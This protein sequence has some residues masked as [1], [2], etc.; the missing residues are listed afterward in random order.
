MSFNATFDWVARGGLT[1]TPTTQ[2]PNLH[3]HSGGPNDPDTTTPSGPP[4]YRIQTITPNPSYLTPA[5]WIESMMN[6]LS[7]PSKSLILLESRNGPQEPGFAA[8]ED[9]LRSAI[10]ALELKEEQTERVIGKNGSLTDYFFSE[11][12]SA[13][14]DSSFEL[15]FRWTSMPGCYVVFMGRFTPKFVTPGGKGK[16]ANRM[17]GIVSHRGLFPISAGEGED[18]NENDKKEK[19]EK[20]KNVIMDSDLESALGKHAEKLGQNPMSVFTVLLQLCESHLD[21]EIHEL[22]VRIEGTPMED[23]AL[24]V[25]EVAPEISGVCLRSI[26]GVRM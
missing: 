21:E 13:S 17:V 14:S 23:F 19:K 12:Q 4:H 22:G 25:K 8:P 20:K 3:I 26:S 7:Q 1:F 5:L 15:A 9:V 10:N 2:D 6:I 18:E 16:E 24:V 11:S